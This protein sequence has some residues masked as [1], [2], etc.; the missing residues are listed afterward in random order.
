MNEKVSSVCNPG[1][2]IASHVDAFKAPPTMA[3][4]GAQ[5]CQDCKQADADGNRHWVDIHPPAFGP[6]FLRYYKDLAGGGMTRG[7]RIN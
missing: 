2:G 1:E 4:V 3:V 6:P 7:K 5:G